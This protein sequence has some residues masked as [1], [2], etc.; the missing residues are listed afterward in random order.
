M[1][2]RMRR[3]PHV[4]TSARGDALDSLAP[5]DPLV[6]GPAAFEHCLGDGLTAAGPTCLKPGAPCAVTTRC[7]DRFTGRSRFGLR[8]T[9][10]TLV[11]EDFECRGWGLKLE[12]RPSRKTLQD[13]GTRHDELLA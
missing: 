7:Q 11:E 13:A 8:W 6:C 9:N 3:E 10:V 5:F 1:C 4:D 12:Q 2:F